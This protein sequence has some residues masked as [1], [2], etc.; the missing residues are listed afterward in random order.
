MTDGAVLDAR[1]A[2]PTSALLVGF[3]VANRAVAAALVRRGHTVVAIDD[4]A[5]EEVREAASDLGIELV[6]NPPDIGPHVAAVDLVVPTPGLP[7]W[8]PVFAAS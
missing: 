3:G 5:S 1:L 8:H 7:E 4:Q 2:Q 6:A